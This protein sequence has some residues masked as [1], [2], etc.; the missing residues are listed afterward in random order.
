MGKIIALS[1]H[2]GGV[3]KS[4]LAMNL[5]AALATTKKVL[6]IDLDPQGNTSLVMLNDIEDIQGMYDVLLENTPIE[7]IIQPTN[8]PNLDI[9]PTNMDLCQAEMA[10]NQEYGRE[11]ILRRKLSPAICNQYDYIIIDTQPSLG[12]L[13]VN[14]FTTAD[15]V[16]I[17]V[18]TKYLSLRVIEHLMSSIRKAQDMLFSPIQVLGFVVNMYNPRLSTSKEAL[19]KMKS[20][21]ATLVFDTVI[22]T[23]AQLDKAQAAHKTVFEYDPTCYGAK[24]HL[25]LA[26]EVNRKAS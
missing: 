2:K 10:L 17:P 1:S 26:N 24:D 15:Y 18:E 14:A 6:L 20:K 21:F 3:G 4:T 23:D 7:A 25:R 8:T 19:E 11:N 16:L 13:T 5:S 12:L 9:A 22:R